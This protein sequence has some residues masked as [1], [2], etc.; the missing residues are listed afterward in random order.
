MNRSVKHLHGCTLAGRDGSLGAVREMYFDEERWTI[1]YIVAE[2]A[3]DFEKHSA[4]LSPVSVEDV[5]WKNSTILFALTREFVAES[6]HVEAGEPISR[7]KERQLN[8]YY[9]IPTYWNGVGLW[10]N[11]VYPGLLAGQSSV[12]E[13][14]AGE[15]E[16]GVRVHSATETFGYRIEAADGDIG[17]VDDLIVE[18][19]TWEI[20]FLVIDTQNWLPGGKVIVDT[21][22]IDRV[23]WRGG[24]VSVSLPRNA[25]RGATAI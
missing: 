13:Q 18:E 5:D 24:T 10:G 14:P 21:D 6:P 22:W 9:G 7:V 17:H 3:D 12:E 8:R 4:A 16:N 23:D 11:H 1:R 25:I 20:Q 2:L 19:R 15:Q